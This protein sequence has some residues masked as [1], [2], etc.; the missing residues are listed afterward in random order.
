MD[1]GGSYYSAYHPAKKQRVVT[2]E[3]K[4]EVIA[5]HGDAGTV[6]V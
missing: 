3:V 1:L 6:T 2:L 4:L 5:V